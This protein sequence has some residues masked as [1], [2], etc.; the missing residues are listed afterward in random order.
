M[1]QNLPDQ[2][3]RPFMDDLTRTVDQL[4]ENLP[5]CPNCT[6]WLKADELCNYQCQRIR[7]PAEVIAFGCW[8]F[9]H[10]IPF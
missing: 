2:N 3:L 4:K 6:H 8:A 1:S 7:P 10:D 9:E 5:C